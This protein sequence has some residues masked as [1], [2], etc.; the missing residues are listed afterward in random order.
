MRCTEIH[1]STFYLQDFS[2]RNGHFVN[3]SIMISVDSND[4]VQNRRGGIG[5][6]CQ[7]EE[8]VVGEV[9]NSCLVC[10]SPIFNNQCIGFIFQTIGHFYFQITGKALFAICGCIVEY[11]SRRIRLD[12]IPHSGV[13]TCGSTVQRIWSIVDCQIVFFA[14]KSEFSFGYTVS[15]ASDSG[16]EERFG[17][18]DY[19][20]YTVMS[21][22]YVSILPVFVGDH[23]GKD[24]ASVV[25]Y[26]NFHSLSIFKNK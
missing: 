7:I 18:V 14:I 13:E 16:V 21:Q 2:C 20:V 26:C 1:R 10:G 17:A 6:T 8:A 3:G 15:V 25:S 11:N 9:D 4:V 24:S 12:C 19:M 22:N 5:N 23:N